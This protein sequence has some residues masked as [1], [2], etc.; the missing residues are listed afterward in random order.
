M[1]ALNEVQIVFAGQWPRHLADCCVPVSKVTGRQLLSLA[2][3]RELNIPR[4]RRSTF[5]SLAFSVAGPSVLNS[6]PNSLHDS[7]FKSERVSEGLEN[8]S[9]C[10][11]LET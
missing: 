5:S 2:S 1:H 3:R 9:L 7:A 8:A 4:F 6:L 11:T 10:R